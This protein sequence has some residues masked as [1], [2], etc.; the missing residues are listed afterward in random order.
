MK[1]ACVHADLLKH[2]DRREVVK[3]QVHLEVGGS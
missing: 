2:L 3:L 1:S